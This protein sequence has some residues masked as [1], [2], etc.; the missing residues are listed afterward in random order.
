MREFSFHLG[1]VHSRSHELQ[2]AAKTRGGD[3]NRR[4]EPLEFQIALHAAQQRQNPPEPMILVQWVAP[5][6]FLHKSCVARGHLD[7]GPVMFVAVEIDMLHL[8]HQLMPNGSE[9][10]EPF[11]GLDPGNSLGFLFREL[12]PFPKSCLLGRLAEKQHFAKRLVLRVGRDQQHRLLLF[13]SAQIKQV[14]I[15]IERHAA[16]GRRGKHVVGID[17]RQ[18]ARQKLL[19]QPPAIRF[20]QPHVKGLV[21]HKFNR[22]V[23][24]AE[25]RRRGPRACSPRQPFRRIDDH[26]VAQPRRPEAAITQWS[27]PSQLCRGMY[28]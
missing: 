26:Y 1:F 5:L 4:P 25:G 12:V 27:G 17:D 9:L 24:W 21:S 20:E 3:R 13:D 15:G 22:G 7:R 28:D 2:D 10:G 11:D 14:G 23:N 19:A 6:A 16:I 18:R 8:A